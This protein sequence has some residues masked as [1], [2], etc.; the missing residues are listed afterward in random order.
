MLRNAATRVSRRSTGPRRGERSRLCVR[1]EAQRERE[2]GGV[3]WGSGGRAGRLGGGGGGGGRRRVVGGCGSRPLCEVRVRP[4]CAPHVAPHYS[5]C[6]E[7]RVV[8]AGGES[9]L[10]ARPAPLRAVA[11]APPAAAGPT[12]PRVARPCPAPRPDA[13]RR[14]P[15]Y[16]R[17]LPSPSRPRPLGPATERS[18]RSCSCAPAARAPGRTGRRARPTRA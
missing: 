5:M 7:P 17:C 18:R 6:V 16:R 14:R 3:G 2:M 8:S 4:G 1:R 9:C 13:A 10:A 12:A 11:A 15:R